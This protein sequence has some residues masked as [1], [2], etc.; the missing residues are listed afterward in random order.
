MNSKALHKLS[1]G[2]HVVGAAGTSKINGQIANAVMQITSD[3]QTVAISINKEN[4]THGLIKESGKFALSVISESAPMT[5][6]GLFGFKS[7]RNV[8][9]FGSCHYRLGI[10]GAPILLD[11]TAA[12]L[13]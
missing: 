13:E 4:L 1:Y 7:G 6:I 3:P 2:L 11:H 9:K 12:Y 10:T 5:L 8:D